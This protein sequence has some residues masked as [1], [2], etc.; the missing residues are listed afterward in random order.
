MD[1]EIV[2][3]MFDTFFTT[4]FTRRGLG[5]SAVYGIINAHK[6]AFLVESRPGAGTSVTIVL[7]VAD[8]TG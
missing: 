2:Q 1:E 8:T 5:M 6:R 4:K 3:K 7:P